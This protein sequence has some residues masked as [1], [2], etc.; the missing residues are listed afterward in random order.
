MLLDPPHPEASLSP[1][2]PLPSQPHS[3]LTFTRA[4]CSLRQHNWPG[5]L[6]RIR[7]T[8]GGEGECQGRNG[9]A[10]IASMELGYHLR[11]GPG[12]PG[13]E[14]AE[15]EE[16][17]IRPPEPLMRIHGSLSPEGNVGRTPPWQ[18]RQSHQAHRWSSKS[19][20]RRTQS[21]IAPSPPQLLRPCKPWVIP[22]RCHPDQ[23][24]APRMVM[25]EGSV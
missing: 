3:L 14:G 21:G 20:W 2:P 10:A 5:L 4:P 12:E 15:Q 8:E 13:Q 11:V 1:I 16:P 6:R 22:N 23:G 9:Q 7:K 19:W 25:R 24:S 18:S 17:D